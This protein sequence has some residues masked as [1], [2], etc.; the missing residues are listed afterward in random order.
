M[1]HFECSVY[2]ERMRRKSPVM[3]QLLPGSE[4]DIELVRKKCRRLVLRRAAMSASVSA[5]PVPG[6][7]I[8][9]DLG[10]L[11]RAIEDINVEFGLAPDQVA[12]LQPK[13]R[14]VIYE[15]TVGMGGLMIGKV[16]TREVV[17][18]MLQ[19]GGLKVFARH[20]AKIVPIA[21]QIAAASIGFA[22]FRYLANQHIDAC[23]QLASD[24]LPY[25]ETATQLVDD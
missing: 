15:M 20:A 19:R 21:G 8:A 13:M 23:A 1:L 9:S 5:I 11:A 12:R 4:S 25:A 2:L 10:F 18:R 7:D 22:T 17:A 24:L 14:L 16:I 6:L 3:W